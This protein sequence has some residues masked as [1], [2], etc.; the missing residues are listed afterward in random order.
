MLYLQLL[1]QTI[2]LSLLKSRLNKGLEPT[3]IEP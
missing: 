2:E 3:S 1:A